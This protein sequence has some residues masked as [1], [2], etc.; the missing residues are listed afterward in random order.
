MCLPPVYPQTDDLLLLGPYF[1][2]IL[3]KWLPK[4]LRGGDKQSRVEEAWMAFFRAL[5]VMLKRGYP[6]DVFENRLTGDERRLIKVGTTCD[7]ESAVRFG[8]LI[9]GFL[10]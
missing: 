3:G 5:A 6:E 8:A 4:H 2:G 7:G 1:V 9:K 10:R